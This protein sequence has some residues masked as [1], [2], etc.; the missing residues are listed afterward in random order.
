MGA[1]LDCDAW[2]VN[3]LSVD[4]ERKAFSHDN[5]TTG[6]NETSMYC[7]TLASVALGSFAVLDPLFASPCRRTSA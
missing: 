5:L 6:P 4:D 3:V 1:K 7:E 2:A